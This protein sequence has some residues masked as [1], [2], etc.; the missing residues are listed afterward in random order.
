MPVEARPFLTADWRYLA[1]LNYAVDPG[2]LATLTPPGTELDHFDGKTYIS[3]VGFRFERTR[4]RGMWIPFHS[5]FDEVNLR[6]YVKRMYEGQQRRGVV[7][8]REI[9]PRWAIAK[10]ARVMY[11]EN[12]IALPMQH[13]VVEPSSTTKSIE[14]TYRWRDGAT[15]NSI[16]V[17]SSGQPTHPEEGSFEQFI[18]EHYWG[19]VRQ[20]D[21]GCVEYR[22][23]HVPWRVWNASR[24]KYEGDTTRLYGAPLAR[25]LTGEP[26]S[27]FLAEGSSV[28]VYW[29]HR[30]A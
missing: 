18:T 24:A 13:H 14:V 28:A 2:V 8:I 30:I 12:Y 16:G 9:V 11:H 15:W 7:F 3:L 27:A 22:V 19:Y 4:V 6:F 5:D 10:I 20:P 1:M 25:C 21:G 29:G 23:E 17:E 26:D